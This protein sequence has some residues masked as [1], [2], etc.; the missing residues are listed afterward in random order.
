MLT[1]VLWHLRS[2]N[3]AAGDLKEAL[4]K[5]YA[6]YKLCRMVRNAHPQ[7]CSGATP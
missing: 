3:E 6:L 4:L 1:S 2:V 7:N 5:A